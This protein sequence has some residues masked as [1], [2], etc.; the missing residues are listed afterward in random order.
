MYSRHIVLHSVL[1]VLHFFVLIL[2]QVPYE[3]Y[4]LQRPSHVMYHRDCLHAGFYK[5]LYP[6]VHVLQSG[7]RLG[8]LS[9]F[10]LI[11]DL[12][13]FHSIPLVPTLS[14]QALLR[15]AAGNELIKT[16]YDLANL[17]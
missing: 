5:S 14:P 6:L 12:L 13:S 16:S 11:S 8:L 4:G 2:L 17:I 9:T 3:M 15:L 1:L 10:F 7:S